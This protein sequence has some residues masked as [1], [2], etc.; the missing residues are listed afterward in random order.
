MGIQSRRLSAILSALISIALCGQV[1]PASA[2]TP[3]RLADAV[4]LV[5]E[6][7]SELKAAESRIRASDVLKTYAGLLP[8][9]TLAVELEDFLG[10]GVFSRFSSTQTTVRLRHTFELGN[11]RGAKKDIASARLSAE[12][13]AYEW[14]RL[15][16]LAE[17]VVRFVHATADQHRLEIA[18]RVKEL[19]E[20]GLEF[21]TRRVKSGAGSV[22]EQRR[23]SIALARNVITAEHA[24]HELRASKRLLSMMWGNSNTEVGELEAE[25]FKTRSLPTY[26]DLA[27]HVQQSPRLV[28]IAKQQ[29]TQRAELALEESEAVP[30]LSLSVG[31]R[32][33]QESEAFGMVFGVSLP[34]PLFQRNR[35]AIAAV[36]LKRKELTAQHDAV[37]VRIL[38]ELYGYVQELTHAKV[39]LET[40]NRD[41]LPNVES[42]L[43]LMT[44]GYKTGRFSQIEM[45]DAQ[46]TLADV[47]KERIDAAERMWRLA[48]QI[49]SLLGIAPQGE[50]HE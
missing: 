13:V 50:L 14:T 31:G 12:K 45:L 18:T 41:V 36:E 8:N 47:E 49:N 15:Q 1:Q 17:T 30:D 28:E 34:L 35:G 11:K 19:A 4:N 24:E 40:L 5:L 23:A 25:L 22:V 46:Q 3:L 26:E 43:E 48:V 33:A 42:V 7:N 38:A 27:P 39:E 37:R 16:I 29:A 9:P 6:R 20:Q 32:H 10:N 2:S 21:V 44:D